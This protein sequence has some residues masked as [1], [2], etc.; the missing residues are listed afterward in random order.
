MVSMPMSGACQRC[1]VCMVAGDG[2]NVLLLAKNDAEAVEGDHVEIE[3]SAGRVVSAAFIIYMVPVFLTIAGFVFGHWLAG[4]DDESIL[5][6]ILAV[7]FLIV[8]FVGVAV[9]DA[10]LRRGERHEARI[11]RVL[12]DD[13]VCDHE[14]H[15]Q[16]VTMG[17]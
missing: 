5:P 10:K 15:V 16:T 17:E 13:E 12:T 3:I 9:Y 14:H 6:I 4:G 8:S 7:A 2:H 11:I 1:G